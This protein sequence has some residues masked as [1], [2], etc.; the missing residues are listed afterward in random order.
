MNLE[1]FR[2]WLVGMALCLG[3]CSVFFKPAQLPPAPAMPEMQQTEVPMVTIDPDWWTLFNDPVLNQLQAQLASGNLNMQLLAARVRQAQ[4]SLASAQSSV[5]PT[6]TLNTGVSRGQSAGGQPAN[7]WSVTAPLSWELDVWG[8]LDATAT[9][10][11]AS[12]QASR[13]DLALARLSAQASLV[14]TYVAIRAAEQQA[15]VLTLALT[16]YAR[17]FQLTQYRYDAGVVSAADVAQAQLQVSSTQAQLIAVNSNRTQLLH[18]LDVLLGQAPGQLELAPAASLPAAPPLPEVVPASLLQR[19]PDVRAAQ[20]RVLSAQANAGAAQAA[21][22]PSLS[23]TATAGYSNNSL[24]NLFSASNL[25]WSMGPGLALNLLDGG[26]RKAAEAEA[27]AALDAAGIVYRQTV[28][29]GLQEVQDN[30]VAAYQLQLQSQ[31]Q[32]QALQAAQRNL[33]ISEA[34]Y[35]AG[36]V[37][38]LNVVTAQTAALNAERS[39][40]DIHSRRVLAVTQL[41]K[42]LGGRL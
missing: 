4:A 42:N 23:F 41:M 16:A 36:T 6:A 9:A 39:V 2:W 19:R 3:G 8:R 27:L 25:L 33:S 35:A 1:S 26:K 37:S 22:F 17:A 31:A 32:A 29:Q 15:A 21:F 18:A 40:L 38:Y 28:L 14:Q 10:A 34:Q 7:T 13:E 5:W 20:Q 12:L 24:G 11:Q 30:L